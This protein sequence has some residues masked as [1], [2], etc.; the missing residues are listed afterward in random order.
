MLDSYTFIAYI[1]LYWIPTLGKKVTKR[2]LI[3]MTSLWLFITRKIIERIDCNVGWHFSNGRGRHVDR[4]LASYELDFG[5][6]HVL[7]FSVQ[8]RCFAGSRL[9]G[10]APPACFDMHVAWYSSSERMYHMQFSSETC[11]AVNLTIEWSHRYKFGS[12]SGHHIGISHGD[13]VREFT[14]KCISL[15]RCSTTA[16]WSWIVWL[17]L[18]P[19]HHEVLQRHLAVK[20]AVGILFYCSGLSTNRP[21]ILWTAGSIIGTSYHVEKAIP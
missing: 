12:V 4:L 5:R 6:I 21:T 15:Q 3:I 7:T 9:L 19:F 13:G 8:I 16:S 10:A 14:I 18:C 20:K 2:P 17:T 11:V 1:W